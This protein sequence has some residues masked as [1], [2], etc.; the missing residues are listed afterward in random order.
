MLFD[1]DGARRSVAVKRPDAKALAASLAKEDGLDAELTRGVA[2]D[3]AELLRARA[4][5]RAVG[6]KHE[7]IGVA[8]D[9]EAGEAIALAVKQTIGCGVFS[10]EET[11]AFDRAREPSAKKSWADLLAL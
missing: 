7:M 10:D 5:C 9:D 8:I 3:L 4:R 1:K 6:S 11:A 2:Q